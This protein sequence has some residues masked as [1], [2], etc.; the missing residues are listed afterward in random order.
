MPSYKF[1]SCRFDCL[2]FEKITVCFH[3]GYITHQPKY[4]R[5]KHND[6]IKWTVQSMKFLIVKLYPLLILTTPEY[7]IALSYAPPKTWD[8]Y[9]RSIVKNFGKYYF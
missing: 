7:R 1:P 8:R 3:F 9:E 6:L 2:N 4:S 5:Y